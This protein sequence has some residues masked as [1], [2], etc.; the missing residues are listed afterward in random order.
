VT[1]INDA[2]SLTAAD[3]SIGMGARGSDAALEQADVI[4]MQDKIENVEEAF[5]LSRR[6]RATIRQNIVISLGVILFLIVSALAEKINLTAG[7]IGHEG[8]TVVVILNGLRLQHADGS[9]VGGESHSFLVQVRLEEVNLVTHP[10]CRAEKFTV[11]I[12][13]AKDGDFHYSQPLSPTC[14]LQWTHKTAN[15]ILT[16]GMQQY[17]LHQERCWE[18]EPA[19][20]IES[21]RAGEHSD[22]ITTSQDFFAPADAVWN[23]LMFYEEVAAE[24]PFLLRRFLPTPIGTEG[25]KSEVGG[26]VT[27]RYVGGHLLKRVTHIIRGHTYAFHLVE[28]NLALGRIRV[29]GGNYSLHKLSEDRTRVALETRYASPNYPRWLFGRLEAAICHSF[30]HYIL[31]AMRSRL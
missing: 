11:V 22:S 16:Q 12:F 1:E 19:T 29:L 17:S 13:C 23:A 7:V 30:H 10:V 15:L 25:L 18:I 2:P 3:V 4:L 5:V 26:E 14:P 27:C 24:R 6:A 8:S 20:K 31:S 9:E 21:C 28:Q